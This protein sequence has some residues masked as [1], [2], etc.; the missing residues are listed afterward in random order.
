[1]K[2]E[3]MGKRMGRMTSVET[4]QKVWKACKLQQ[5]R[6]ATKQLERQ[7]GKAYEGG[8]QSAGCGGS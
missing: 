6:K 3:A 4:G 1:M 5:Q 8:T 7:A 2:E